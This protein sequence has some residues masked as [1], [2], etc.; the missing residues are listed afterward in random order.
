MQVRSLKQLRSHV[1]TRRTVLTGV[2]LGESIALQ[3][4]VKEVADSSASLLKSN[5]E[6][7]PWERRG[8]VGLGGIDEDTPRG[9]EDR[10][11]AHS[12]KLVLDT[13]SF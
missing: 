13:F 12:R 6:I 4:F 3:G 2:V 5:P 7:A 8:R 11:H 1:S 9:R 10:G